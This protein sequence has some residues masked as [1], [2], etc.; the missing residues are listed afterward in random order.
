MNRSLNTLTIRT[1]FILSVG[2]LTAII[3]TLCALFFYVNAQNE[4]SFH[5][6]QQA[7]DRYEAAGKLDESFDDLLYLSAELS[8]SLSDESYDAFLAASPKVD[9][10]ISLVS[11]D[12]FQKDL[13]DKKNLI[14][15]YALEALD[16]Y[17]VN[18]RNE[19]D[20]IMAMMRS[21]TVDVEKDLEAHIAHYQAERLAETETINKRTK[22]IQNISILAAI[23][24][25]FIMATSFVLIWK[26]LFRPINDLINTISAASADTENASRYQLSNLT[27]NETG[28]AGAALNRLLGVVEGSLKES[29]NR[30]RDAETAEK[31][32]Q[33][34]F[35]QSP[36]AII[37]VDPETTEILEKN[38]AATELLVGA[39]DDAQ[40]GTP[41][42]ALAVHHHEVEAL[43]EFF[44][45]ILNDGYARDDTFSCAIKKKRIPISAV[46]VIFP[47]DRKTNLLLHI[48][49]ISEQR[50][51]EKELQQARITAEKANRA[52]T[53]FLANMSHEIRTPM[54][55]VIGMAEV[56]LGTSL[57]KKQHEMLSII[58]SSG[59]SL[60]SVIN[61]I[62]DF[63][64]LEVGKL[65][66]APESFELRST[67]N[68]IENL[69]SAQAFAKK[70]TLSFDIDDDIPPYIIADEVRIRQILTN[71]VGNAVKFTENGAVNVKAKCISNETDTTLRVEVID[72]GIGISVDD[73]SRIFEK[74]EQADRSKTRRFDGTGL[75]LA[76]CKELLELMDGKI[77]VDSQLNQGSTFWFETKTPIDH[78]RKAPAS[79]KCN[80]D[81]LP[82]KEPCS[83]YGAFH[84]T[85]R[86]IP[87]RSTKSD[88]ISPN[89]TTTQD[90]PLILIAEDNLGN[91]MVAKTMI[92]ETKYK[93]EIVDNGAFAVDFYRGSRPALVIMDLSMPVM[94]GFEATQLIRE[95]E[96]ANDLPRTPVVALT[97]HVLAE[98]QQGC[99]DAGMDD[100]MTKPLR[101]A[102]IDQ[103][104]ENW[105]DQPDETRHSA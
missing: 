22:A 67:L 59:T 75:G 56:L 89:N 45:K 28:R 6:Q 104:L 86:A 14:E 7:V 10:H 31:R 27:E 58:V 38:P 105:L 72:S 16:A 4:K 44:G 34:L 37:L 52:K 95:F 33:T 5:S 54:N 63:S 20:H 32:W 53:D 64:K 92:D 26:N 41:L 99:I 12:A 18:E 39:E 103:V 101:K 100:I 94:D 24:S 85:P 83:A 98:H 47:N 13:T 2:L 73:K 78:T 40:P 84:I 88:L 43:R 90:K 25:F 60:V 71:L 102:V 8:N 97:A 1:N 19:G 11:N 80:G 66:I 65:R 62:L 42:T 82:P 77:G 81:D 29:R 57:D 30:A 91:Q 46:G 49:D 48:R 79:K 74:F 17:I 69:F 9:Y 35:G 55:G 21:I 23:F 15:Q 76:I 36:D 3:V 70:I 96:F 61:D 87:S 50:S 68:E 93:I 51:Y